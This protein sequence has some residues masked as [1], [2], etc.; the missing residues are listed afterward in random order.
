VRSHVISPAT[1]A[2]SGIAGHFAID[3]APDP[4]DLLTM[5]MAR[6]DALQ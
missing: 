1:A 5:C 2:A 4:P 3:G 6:E